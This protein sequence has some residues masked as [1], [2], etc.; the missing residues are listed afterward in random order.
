MMDFI[1]III[2]I[3]YSPNTAVNL[4]P[5]GM[6]LKTFRH[7]VCYFRFRNRSR[8]AIS[9]SCI[10]WIS[11]VDWSVSP[12]PKPVSPIVLRSQ[13]SLMCK[14]RRGRLLENLFRSR[15]HYMT[16]NSNYAIN[17]QLCYWLCIWLVTA[18]SFVRT[19]PHREF[20]CDRKLPI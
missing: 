9:T 6:S 20:L 5:L 4:S 7:I 17:V 8:T 11:N 13:L 18:M 16:R 12:P 1:I 3:I 10:R 2:I 19:E 14:Q 15:H